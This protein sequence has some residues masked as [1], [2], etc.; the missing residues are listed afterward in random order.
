MTTLQGNAA[1]A[2][3]EKDPQRDPLTARLESVFAHPERS[4]N[5]DLHAGVDDVLKDVGL[6]TSDSGGTLTFYGQ[7]P[8]IASPFRFGTMAA[9]GLAAKAVAI[10]SLWQLRTGE[11]Q[12][13]AL[14]VRKALRRFAGFFDLK[15]ET[16]NGRPPAFFEPLNPFID[17]PIF[18]E[19][20]DGRHVVA[21]S[22]Y[23]RLAARGLSLLRCGNTTESVRNAILQWRAE[24]LENA[25]AEAGLPFAMVRTFEEFRKEPQYTEV[26]S[27]MP[28]ISVEKIGE[29]APVLFKKDG[30]NPLDGIRAFGMGHVIAGAGIGR[31]LAYSGADVLNIWRPNDTEIESF[32][33]DVQV[34]MRSTILDYSREDRARFDH[35]LKDADIFFANKRPGYLERLGLDADELCAKKPGLIHARVVL[36]GDKG[37]WKNRPGFDEIG[38]A[39]SGLF[40]VEGTPTQPKSPP[41]IP[42]CDNVVGWLGTVGVLAAL[43]RRAIEGGSYRVTVSLTR[44]LL[45]LYSLGILDKDYAKATA[46]SSEEHADVAPDLFTAETP[47][48]TYQGMTD[49]LVMSRT[50]GSFR[51]VLVPRGSSKPEWLTR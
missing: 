36:H 15:W 13:I 43:R 6:S 24:E 9:L 19:T 11:G 49:Q 5:F 26:L 50:P 48:G 4:A 10:A 39:V 21:L 32:A 34:G 1:A 33:W 18:R 47:L 35:L 2:L 22:I 27:G 38:G 37:P 29:S 28:L 41:I 45:W 46:G 14:D 8:I 7:D 12:D 3:L 44:T 51:T 20:R 17:V 31:D 40:C 42:I 16:I 30:K 23:P 25:A